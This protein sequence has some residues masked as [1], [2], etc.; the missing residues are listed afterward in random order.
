MVHGPRDYQHRLFPYL[1]R[2]DDGRPAI[3][4]DEDRA[5]MRVTRGYVED[6]AA[7]IALAATDP[8]ASGT[9]RTRP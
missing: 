7:A 3:V 8:R 5:R 4:L 2:M 9:A 1:K 6:V